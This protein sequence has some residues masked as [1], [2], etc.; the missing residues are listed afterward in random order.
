MSVRV[1][2]RPWKILNYVVNEPNE[3]TT[4]EISEDLEEDLSAMINVVIKLKN[5]G[6]ITTGKTVGRAKALVP[7]VS[8]IQALRE[9]VKCQSVHT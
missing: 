6:Y 2:G 5:L 3:W 7:T 9:A 1:F 8:G 4:R